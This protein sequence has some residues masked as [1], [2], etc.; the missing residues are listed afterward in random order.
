[1]SVVGQK[2]QSAVVDEEG[3]SPCFGLISPRPL[4]EL[5]G[6]ETAVRSVL[7]ERLVPGSRPG[8]SARPGGDRPSWG[9]AW[10][11]GLARPTRPGAVWRAG[12]GAGSARGTGLDP[13]PVSSHPLRRG[14]LWTAERQDQTEM[15]KNKRLTSA[16]S[17]CGAGDGPLSGGAAGPP[18]C[19]LRSGGKPFRGTPPCTEGAKRV[20]RVSVGTLLHCVS[21]PTAAVA[22]NAAVVPWVSLSS[23]WAEANPD[24]V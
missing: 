8:A 1:M 13:A 17:F 14:P 19:S 4:L 10:N 2:P 24:L 9:R 15:E 18:V 22:E 5:R 7:R 11:P 6:V 23:E 12:G 3:D 16:A 21:S 20:G